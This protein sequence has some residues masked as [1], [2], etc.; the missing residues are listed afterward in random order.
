VQRSVEESGTRHF[1]GVHVVAPAPAYETAARA[2]AEAMEECGWQVVVGPE[3]GEVERNAILVFTLCRFCRTVECDAGGIRSA[4]LRIGIGIRGDD[5][6]AVCE[7]R[8]SL[9]FDATG[10]N[11]A[12]GN[13]EVW[14]GRIGRA[15]VLLRQVINIGG[16]QHVGMFG[17]VLNSP[18]VLLAGGGRQRSASRCQADIRLERGRVAEVRCETA[19][20]QIDGTG[21]D[22]ELI[23]I[24]FRDRSVARVVVGKPVL[25]SSKGEPQTSQRCL[26]LEVEAV[27]SVPLI[28]GVA[29]GR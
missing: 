16:D 22:G 14:I 25:A 15:D 23:G 3:R 4:V 8:V 9:H 13:G 21:S 26:I 6:H 2:H 1:E 19:P 29:I 10:P 12:D 11:L 27:L 17:L 28:S 24:L 18:L 5:A 7:G 20:N